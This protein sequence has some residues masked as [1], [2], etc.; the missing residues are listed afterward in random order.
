M[1]DDRRRDGAD[2]LVADLT[3]GSEGSSLGLFVPLGDSVVF[4]KYD[5]MNGGYEL[6]ISDGTAAGSHIVRDF[7]PGY[8][9]IRDLHPLG[10]NKVVFTV[11]GRLWVSD[12]TEEG[13]HVVFENVYADSFYA[14]GDKVIFRGDGQAWISDGTEEGT[15]VLA[16]DTSLGRV[17]VN[18]D[19]A[20]LSGNFYEEGVGY[21]WRIWETDG[22]VDGTHLLK[23]FVTGETNG[24]VG[25]FWTVGDKTLFEAETSDNHRDLWVSDGTP[26]GTVLLKE[27]APGSTYS[28]V[29]DLVPLGETAVF[30]VE[31]DDGD[32]LWVTDGTTDGT[33]FVEHINAAGPYSQVN[34]ITEFNGRAYFS[35]NDGVHGAELWVSDGTEAGT[36]LLKDINPSNAGGGGPALAAEGGSGRGPSDFTV[37]NGLL[38]FAADDGV[39]GREL[40]VTDGTETGTRMVKEIN[41]TGDGGVQGLQVV[42][43][44]LYFRGSNGTSGEELWVTDGTSGGTRLVKDINI[45]D[46]RL[47]P[48]GIRRVRGPR[49]FHRNECHGAQPLRSR[50]EW[51]GQPRSADSNGGRTRRF[52]SYRRACRRQACVYRLRHRERLGALVAR[53]FPEHDAAQGHSSRRGWVGRLLDRYHWRQDYPAR[54]RRGTRL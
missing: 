21:G 49:L 30:V 20:F 24:F 14:F 18:G 47:L 34:D 4:Q 8:E 36:H 12:G 38:Y 6:W 39:N 35:A 1:D 2:V 52:T 48:I 7:N 40:W 46:S 31:T 32:A 23:E 25:N 27:I 43:G 28:Y 17:Y 9:D 3:P 33:Q 45:A 54:Q 44:K 51:C 5:P 19:Q 53:R 41:P 22:T 29:Y 37:Y 16:P 42:G 11:N 26:E 50:Y 13:T 15:H 10:G